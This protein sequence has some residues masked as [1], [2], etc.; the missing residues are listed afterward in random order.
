LIG[1]PIM[2]I[3]SNSHIHVSSSYDSPPSLSHREDCA[4][5]H[6]SVT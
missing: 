5:R 1:V 6:K 4:D 2:D 3:L